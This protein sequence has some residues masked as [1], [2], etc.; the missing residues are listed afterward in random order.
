MEITKL[1]PKL[2]LKEVIF[3]H[4]SPLMPRSVLESII[5]RVII[6]RSH[7]RSCGLKTATVTGERWK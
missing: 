1:Q 6:I 7:A 5:K 2:D 4:I 3:V